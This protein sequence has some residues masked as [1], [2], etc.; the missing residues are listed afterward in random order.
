RD[1]Y[2]GESRAFR[3]W[4]KMNKLYRRAAHRTL[5][6]PVVLWRRSIVK[7]LDESEEI[8]NALGE[9]LL[10]SVG[11]ERLVLFGGSHGVSS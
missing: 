10:A 9:S 6:P 1:R 3:Y 5:W 7:A 8:L 2:V 4:K 11:L